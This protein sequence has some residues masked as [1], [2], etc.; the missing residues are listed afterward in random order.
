MNFLS[1][2]PGRRVLFFPLRLIRRHFSG[3]AFLEIHDANLPFLADLERGKLAVTAPIAHGRFRDPEEL[4]K[5]VH[6]VDH[7][8]LCHTSIIYQTNQRQPCPFAPGNL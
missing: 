3:D 5:L 6:A 2:E 7:F 1:D 8:L 4:G